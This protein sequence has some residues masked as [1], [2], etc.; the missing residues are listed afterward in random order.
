MVKK[1]QMTMNKPKSWLGH[2]EISGRVA[3]LI[4]FCK[5]LLPLELEQG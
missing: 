2:A 3:P 1:E 5:E 4:T